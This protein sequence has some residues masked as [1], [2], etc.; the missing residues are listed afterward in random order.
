MKS[1]DEKDQ[2]QIEIMATKSQI[3]EF[4]ENNF[5][6]KDMVNEINVWLEAFE[7]E[8][9][10]IVDDAAENNPSTASVLLHLGDLNGRAK[11]IKYMM[12]LPDLFLSILEEKKDDSS[13]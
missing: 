2:S 11:A 13:R 12:S 6:W 4:K 9:M 5:V 7:G 1:P 3:K 10:S 8:K